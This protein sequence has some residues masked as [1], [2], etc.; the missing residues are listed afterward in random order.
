[1][2]RRELEKVRVARIVLAI[3][4]LALSAT[5]A[6]ANS[7][8]LSDFTNG[9][10]CNL[11]IG[12][13]VGQ[14]NACFVIENSAIGGN[15]IA[16]SVQIYGGD[17]PDSTN[18]AQIT[19]TGPASGSLTTAQI[20]PITWNY[21]VTG[22]NPGNVSLDLYIQLQTSSG[23]FSTDIITKGSTNENGEALFSVGPFAS[24][25]SYTIR[26]TATDPNLSDIYTIN[27]PGPT[28]ISSPG[29]TIDF[30][31]LF[32]S[33]TPEPSSWLIASAGLCLLFWFKKNDYWG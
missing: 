2:N 28:T 22:F 26:L 8:T 27:I 32:A 1:M 33:L 21:Q 29:N 13:V 10:S 6:N 16:D 19:V 11:T 5:P 7:L 14:P 17:F 31:P 23:N 3:L 30:N 24:A 18:T 12:L 15:A 20:F 25:T 9:A 4:P